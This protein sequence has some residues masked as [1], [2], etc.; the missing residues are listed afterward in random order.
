MKISISKHSTSIIKVFIKEPASIESGTISLYMVIDRK[1]AALVGS[2]P[3]D[4]KTLYYEFDLSR[5]EPKNIGDF[6]Y[7][8][9]VSSDHGGKELSKKAKLFKGAP[10]H[11]S[12]AVKKI[13]SDFIRVAKTHN[14]SPIYMF[15]R[16]PGESRCPEC[17]DEDLMASNNSSC[18]VCG[19]KGFMSYYSNPYKSWGSAINFTNEK[20]GTQ[21]QGKTMESTVVNMSAVADFVLTTDDMV[22]YE[23]TGDWYRVKARTISEL[24]TIPTLQ[25]LVM[26]LMPSNAPE[27]EAAYK[28]IYKDE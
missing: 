24:Q 7:Y 1:N 14:G 23:K 4:K 11:I 12:G 25:M 15:K 17:W 2:M 27:T 21:D 6:D 26:D 3:Y 18:P 9:E 16:M 19:G 13:Q 5:K 22:Y 28:L 20:Y 10:H 8:V